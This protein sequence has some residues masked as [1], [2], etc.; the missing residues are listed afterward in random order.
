MP[1]YKRVLLGDR[2]RAIV[3]RKGRF[4]RILGPGE[5]VLF[6]R[7]IEVER[8]SVREVILASEWTDA[9]AKDAWDQVAPY[10]TKVE[11]GDR[12]V[13]IVRF[14]GKLARVIGPAS[15]VLFWRGPVEVTAEVIDA[16]EQPAV[17]ADLVM[18]LSR[19]GR[20]ANVS[21]TAVEEGKAAL[22]YLDNRFVRLLGPGTHAFWNTAATPSVETV[23]LRVQALEIPG[24]EILTRDKVSL[25]VNIWA[26]YQVVDAVRAKTSVK[27]FAEHL[28]RAV[29]L[30]VRQSMGR[31]TL[32]EVLAEK[33]DIDA[34]VASVV[35]TEAEALG[36]RLAA[37][38]IKDIVLPGEVREI[39]NRVVTAEKEAQANLIRRREETAATRSLLNTARLL[40]ENPLLVRLKELETLEKV[41]EKV[42]KITIHGGFDTL[43]NRLVTLGEEKQ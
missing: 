1:F 13:A 8:H 40:E 17:P 19:L 28:Y 9:L 4:D 32:E 43:L 21:F 7:K 29:Q 25:R 41:A 31:R 35:R 37:M 22:L 11:T 14:D 38:A 2:E 23:D 10:F 5:H 24:Q 18:P 26:E 30:A 12:E 3:T 27:D 36:V 39:L 15:R 42:D 20:E 34:A 16:R 6:G 33:T